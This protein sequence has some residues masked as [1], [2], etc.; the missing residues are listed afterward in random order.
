MIQFSLIPRNRFCVFD[1]NLF[2]PSDDDTPQPLIDFVLI[3]LA[4]L[5]FF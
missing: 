4:I 1:K 2:V 5:F 3:I